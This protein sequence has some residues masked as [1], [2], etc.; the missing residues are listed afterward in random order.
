MDQEKLKQAFAKVKQDIDIIKSEIQEL[1]RTLDKQ[2]DTSTDN[3]TH[4]QTE[5]T[6]NSAI[7]HINS[8]QNSI[9]A[10]FPA[11]NLPFKAL[12]SPNSSIS[13][14]NEGVPADRQ[15]TDKQTDTSTRNKGVKVALN[16]EDLIKEANKENKM[17]KLEKVADFISSLD[18]I[19]KDL[20]AKIKRL[21]KQE[22]SVFTAIYNLEEQ[23]FI[24]DYQLLAEKLSL[25]ESSIR[26]YIQ[27]LIKKDI[28]IE[29]SK[30]NNKKIIL[31]I[32][33]NLKKIASLNTILNLREV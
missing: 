12:K 7:Q 33:Q 18:D 19:K 14:G 6:R 31:S 15:Q 23:G 8:T 2:T 1:K 25:T 20:R 26:D 24:I 21:T 16:K 27:R 22:M 28:P 11:D 30:E 13:T 29:K 3:Q 5:S 32:S 17:N 10:H 9:P 4:S